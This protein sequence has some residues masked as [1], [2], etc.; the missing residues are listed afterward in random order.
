MISIA[1]KYSLSFTAASFRL[2]DFLRV[3]SFLEQHNQNLPLKAII[4][5]EILSKGNLKTSKREMT[6]FLKRYNSLNNEQKQLLINGNL[7]DK[8]NIT[9]LAIIKSNSLI[10]DF[11]TEVV[12]DKFLVF[13][14]QLSDA[15]Y[16]GFINRK[17]E[18]HPELEAF[19]DST[20]EKARRTIFKI[21]ADVGFLE[22]TKSK[23]IIKSWLSQH[24]IDVIKKENPEFLKA[25]LFSDADIKEELRK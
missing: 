12:R 11:V 19:S 7:D 2:H 8:K 5:E 23:I 13:D 1:Q 16:T 24:I 20:L 22:S 17:V 10:R 18:L 3:A 4:A 15:D 25:F 14:F 6:E 9:Y 21:L